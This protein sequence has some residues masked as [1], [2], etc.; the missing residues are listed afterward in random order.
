MTRP[1]PS[2]REPG[3]CLAVAAGPRPDGLTSAVGG[4]AWWLGQSPIGLSTKQAAGTGPL[5]LGM[6]MQVRPSSTD[7]A[8]LVV[9]QATGNRQ[10]LG[11]AAGCGC[12][13]RSLSL[14]CCYRGLCRHA[15]RCGTAVAGSLAVVAGWYWPPVESCRQR[16]MP[17]DCARLVWHGVFLLTKVMNV[18]C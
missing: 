1:G 5:Q 10:Y 2:R 8:I 18:L 14:Y 4:P 11:L 13:C 9:V 12:L 16:L 17:C 6:G 3:C 7:W 15:L